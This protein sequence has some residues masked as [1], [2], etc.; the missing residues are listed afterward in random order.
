MKL[1]LKHKS[2]PSVLYAV[3]ALL[4]FRVTVP[5]L[6]PSLR[7]GALK[8]IAFILKKLTGHSVEAFIHNIA[9]LAVEIIRNMAGKPR[10]IYTKG[11][12]R[13]LMAA[14]DAVD[15]CMNSALPYILTV[16]IPSAVVGIG[17]LVYV[18]TKK[19]S[20]ANVG[21]LLLSRSVVLLRAIVTAFLLPVIVYGGVWLT[22]K[23]D[24]P[25]FGVFAV[26][27][28]IITLIAVLHQLQLAA[29]MKGVISHKR[30]GEEP[31]VPVYAAAV[32]LISG[33]LEML[34]KLADLRYYGFEAVLAVIGGAAFVAAG[35]F[36]LV[37]RFRR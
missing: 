22:G 37:R 10:S 30:G 12:S 20:R 17:I 11:M 33:V 23:S 26:A 27:A 31:R 21:G 16:A 14:L 34:P 4:A 9:L 7:F 8:G 29:F 28:A 35:A 13:T 18:I 19:R 15:A 6:V 2:K 25:I 5:V 1:L 24:K 36:M 32:M 3:A